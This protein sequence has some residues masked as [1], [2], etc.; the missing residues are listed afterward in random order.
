MKKI[1][2][3][4]AALLLS[5]CVSPSA[6]TSNALAL[7]GK[8]FRAAIAKLG[9]PTSQQLVGDKTRVVWRYGGDKSF[10][11]VTAVPDAN[12]VVANSRTFY[13]VVTASVDQSGIVTQIRLDANSVYYCP[14]SLR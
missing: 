6:V 4:V 11:T 5:A 2:G 3:F 12:M 1:V 7:K 10:T 9:P 8:S 13:C 14:Q